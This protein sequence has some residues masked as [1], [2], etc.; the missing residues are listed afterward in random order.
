MSH[1]TLG[2]E[3]MK[4]SSNNDIRIE[5]IYK[6]LKRNRQEVDLDK[7]P[8]ENAMGSMFKIDFTWDI[9]KMIELLLNTYMDHKR[10]KLYIKMIQDARESFIDVEEVKKDIE[11]INSLRNKNAELYIKDM[12]Q[13]EK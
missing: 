6:E 2:G 7:I 12:T 9:N 5:E 13:K 10:E 11:F 8:V 4:I 3:S 1:K